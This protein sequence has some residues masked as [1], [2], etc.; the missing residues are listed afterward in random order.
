MVANG[1][2]YSIVIEGA[3]PFWDQSKITYRPL[4]PQ[5][6]ATSVLAWKRGQ[7][8]SLVSTKFIQHIKCLLGMGD[9]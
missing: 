7:P 9:I 2:A 8:F 1:L 6:T 4:F 5:L 3:V